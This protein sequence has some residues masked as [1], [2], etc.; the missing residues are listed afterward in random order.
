MYVV[1]SKQISTRISPLT[2]GG[3]AGGGD[4]EKKQHTSFPSQPDFKYECLEFLQVVTVQNEN[5]FHCVHNV[6]RSQWYQRT[7]QIPSGFYS[8]K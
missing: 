4:K 1:V 2:I 3:S 7:N 8:E 5:F 6:S